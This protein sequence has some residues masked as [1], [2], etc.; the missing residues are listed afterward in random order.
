MAIPIINQRLYKDL[1]TNPYQSKVYAKFLQGKLNYILASSVT[2]ITHG[3]ALMLLSDEDPITDLMKSATDASKTFVPGTTVASSKTIF[4][5]YVQSNVDTLRDRFLTVV[6]SEFE[7]VDDYL[8]RCV[9]DHPI[10]VAKTTF[11]MLKQYKAPVGHRAD[12]IESTNFLESLFISAKINNHRLYGADAPEAARMTTSAYLTIPGP[13][14]IAILKSVVAPLVGGTLTAY[15]TDKKLSLATKDAYMHLVAKMYLVL[16]E[17]M[18]VL[19]VPT[20]SDEVPSVARTTDERVGYDENGR[21]LQMAIA[22]IPSKS[23]EGMVCLSAS[24]T[25]SMAFREYFDEC[26][27]DMD[28]H[29]FLI[30]WYAMCEHYSKMDD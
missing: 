18:G 20:Y 5:E 12:G 19:G 24:K 30:L 29:K 27:M 26:Y 14:L 13:E 15:V 3:V 4:T 7:A 17:L 2:N 28:M 23:P 6:Q 10:P 9:G 25:Y 21:P 16:I 1:S 22:G 11:D 8:Q